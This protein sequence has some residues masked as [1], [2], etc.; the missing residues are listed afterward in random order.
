MSDTQTDTQ[1]SE[2]LSPPLPA[3]LS[4]TDGRY[5]FSL[6]ILGW[7]STVMPCTRYDEWILCELTLH[8]PEAD[9]VLNGPYMLRFEVF[10]LKT[11][12][13][14]CLQSQEFIF[15]S[16]FMETAFKINLQS[17]D[18]QTAV[19]ISFKPPESKTS[20]VHAQ[21]QAGPEQLSI[22]MKGLELQLEDFYSV[23]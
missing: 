17:L 12:V 22:F 20:I 7:E 13:K 2:K 15:Q 6:A 8:T 16:D 3:L 23:L 1:E 14:K 10:D 11:A 9:T 19:L 21:F 4:S 18:S 5:R